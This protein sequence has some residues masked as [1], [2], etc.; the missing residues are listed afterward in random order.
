MLGRMERDNVSG[1]EAIEAVGAAGFALYML[2][3]ASID[4]P[5]SFAC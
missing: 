1:V 2:Q 3:R 4:S 5:P